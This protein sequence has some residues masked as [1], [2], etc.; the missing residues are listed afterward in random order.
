M[1]KFVLKAELKYPTFYTDLK[2]KALIEQMLQKR[3][4]ARINRGF[5][6]LKASNYFDGFDWE[7]LYEKRLKSPYIPK[8]LKIPMK[9]PSD[10]PPIL[11]Y[12]A[13]E[14][15]SPIMA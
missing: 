3:P 12:L 1:H 6:G 11:T 13:K 14:K 5:A 8:K 4:E 15:R 7:G 9:L 2:G 10:G